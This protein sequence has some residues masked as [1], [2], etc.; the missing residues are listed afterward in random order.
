MQLDPCV[1]FKFNLLPKQKH[2]Q[3]MK[4]WL[5]IDGKK[6]GPHHDFEIRS[7]ITM[8]SEPKLDENTAGWCTVTSSRNREET[9]DIRCSSFM[10]RSADA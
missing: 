9:S 3:K 4:I 1:I 10:P 8:S 2:N 7:M 6:D 5:L